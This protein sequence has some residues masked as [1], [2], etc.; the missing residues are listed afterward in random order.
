MK[1][2]L[3]AAVLAAF[4]TGAI[5]Q[6]RPSN[7]P[8]NTAKL[9]YLEVLNIGHAFRQMGNYYDNRQMLVQVPFKFDGGTLL[10]FA[11]NIRAAD[12]AQKA[13][14]E[15]YAKFE[16]QELGDVKGLKPEEVQQKKLAIANS[17]AAK[18][19]QEKPAGALMVRIKE[20]ELC[21]K[22]APVAPCTATNNI[23][24]SILASILPL[25]DR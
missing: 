3:L 6:E 9:T 23:S 11:V 4:S 12:D 19:M 16:A 24:P 10:S 21:M 17:D 13:F 15:A 8:N 14:Q 5:T 25:V 7:D 1:K 22:A 2:F 20:A 18:R